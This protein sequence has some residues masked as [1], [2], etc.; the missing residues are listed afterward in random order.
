M[1]NL[2]V[3]HTLEGAAVAVFVALFALV[4]VL[5]FLAARWRPAD[6]SQL[7]EWGLAGRRF[8]SV[9]AWFLLGADIYTAYTFV[10]VPAVLF[11]SGSIGMFA[12]PYT[13]IV[14]P[15][16]FVVMPRLW[17]VC[18]RHGYVTAADLVR[19]RFGCRTLALVVALTGLLAT[20]P[21]IAVQLKGLEV[22]LDSM[23]LPGPTE[24]PLAVAFAILAA[25]TYHSGLRAPALIGIVKD[26]LVFVVALVVTIH[27]S[28]ELGGFGD[29]FDAARREL[30]GWETKG[31]IDPA[32]IPTGGYTQ[33][34]Y[35]TLA[36]GS[37]LALLLYPHIITGVLS[38]RSP[39]VVRRI[40]VALPAYSLL[41]G[42][43]ALMGY[44]LLAT[45]VVAREDHNY[46]VPDLLIANL[47]PAMTGFAFAAIA[48]A[49]IV[50][51]AI[52]SIAAANLFTRNIYKEYL[53]P[54][55]SDHD[56]ARV[57]RLVSLVVKLGALVFVIFV[58]TAHTLDLQLLGGVWILQTLPAVII[59]LYTDWLDRRA[60]LAGWAA[61]MLTGTVIFFQDLS[62]AI[63]SVEVLGIEISAYEALYALAVNCF[64]TLTVTAALRRR[65]SAP[66]A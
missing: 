35:A 4:T 44:M 18:H 1:P 31:G 64:V 12:L 19:G 5:G 50:P 28:S 36:F 13:I 58:D 17:A 30:P 53:R 7:D 65:P 15:L 59:G 29:I 37:A 43:V 66:A 16:M 22:I 62:T 49:A 23:G 11:S 33:Q 52:M 63:L 24:V 46:V 10:F 42:L 41:L 57:A 38:A 32:L 54:D 6:L 45:P 14:F 20:M 8:G 55:A 2:N 25:Y 34:A 47:P 39:D 3:P 9:T 40:S 48:I 56:E 21:Y 51:V 26:V 27:V 61:G 60:L